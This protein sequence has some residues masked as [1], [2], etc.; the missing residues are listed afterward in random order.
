MKG[1]VDCYECHFEKAFTMW[2]IIG[3][4]MLPMR[5]NVEQRPTAELL[6]AVG[7]SSEVKEKMTSKLPVAKNLPMREQVT[8]YTFGSF[9]K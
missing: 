5:P 1:T 7:N 6:E 9:H 3:D 2:A 8:W 4:K